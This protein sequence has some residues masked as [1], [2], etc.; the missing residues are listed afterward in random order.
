[1]NPPQADRRVLVSVPERYVAGA[2]SRGRLEG[3][4]YPWS[5]QVIH[6]ISGLDLV[7]R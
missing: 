6:G 3:R 1:M 2:N 7:L 4:P 5:Q